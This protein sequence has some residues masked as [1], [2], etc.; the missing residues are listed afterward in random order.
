MTHEFA[1]L[2]RF[3]ITG[4]GPVLLVPWEGSES[5]ETLVGETVRVD[6]VAYLVRAV[7]YTTGHRL[8]T[9]VGLRVR[10]I[11]EDTEPNGAS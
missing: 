9:Q 5:P 2:E 11:T 7:E 6:G 4:V 3:E 8:S 10:P 1:L